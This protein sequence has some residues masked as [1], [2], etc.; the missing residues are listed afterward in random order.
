MRTEASKFEG[1]VLTLPDRCGRGIRHVVYQS[2]SFEKGGGSA[3]TKKRYGWEDTSPPCLLGRRGTRVSLLLLRVLGRV[4][5]ERG[6]EE[7]T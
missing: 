1:V 7:G 6:A 3:A 4:C 5:A 2:I